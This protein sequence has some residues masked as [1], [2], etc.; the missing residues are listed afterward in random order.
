MLSEISKID[1]TLE[2][3]KDFKLALSEEKDLNHLKA[4][5]QTTAVAV[6]GLVSRGKS[7]LVNK[8]IGLDLLPTG[9]NPV[10][11]G[12][13]FLSSG[14][15]EAF[16]ITKSGKRVALPLEPTEFKSRSRRYDGQDLVDFTYS[17]ALRLPEDVMLIDTKGLDE[18][19]ANFRDDLEEMERSWA[20]QGALGAVMVTSVPP[21]MSAQ[22]A[23]LF[24]ELHRHFDGKVLVVVKQTD[25]S[26]TL[27]EI[28]E[29][30][31]VW[32][33]HG[34]D[35]I[36]ISD[37]KPLPTDIWGNGPLSNLENRLSQMWLVGQ[38]A[39]I[40]ALHSLEQTI[41]TLTESIFTPTSRKNFTDEQLDSLWKATN[42][43]SLLPAAKSISKSRLIEHYARIGKVPVD[44]N[45]LEN[46]LK[47]AKLGSEQAL[48]HIQ[49]ATR[50]N[51]KLKNELSSTAIIE[52]ID[53]Y[54]PRILNKTLE[55]FEIDSP[56]EYLQL[57]FLVEQLKDKGSDWSELFKVCLEYLKKI[58][59]EKQLVDLLGKC[60][61]LLVEPTILHLVSLWSEHLTNPN[62]N[63]AGDQ[64]VLKTIRERLEMLGENHAALSTSSLSLVKKIQNFGRD[65]GQ[66]EFQKY[67]TIAR[68]YSLTFS[69]QHQEN[70]FVSLVGSCNRISAVLQR[71]SVLEPAL[72]EHVVTELSQ[73]EDEWGEKSENQRWAR[74]SY[75]VADHNFSRADDYV[76][77]FRW[78]GL[79]FGVL[80]FF[81]LINQA[82]SW[83]ILFAGIAA[84]SALQSNHYSSNYP[85]TID[86]F[87]SDKRSK[88]VEQRLNGRIKG[89]VFAFLSVLILSLSSNFF[90]PDR[91]ES[92]QSADTIFESNQID[93]YPVN[94][95]PPE[96]TVFTTTSIAQVSISN[97]DLEED[98]IQNGR[99]TELV[100]I[101][102]PSDDASRISYAFRLSDRLSALPDLIDVEYCWINVSSSEEFCDTTQARRFS[103]VS[104]S[105]IYAYTAAVPISLSSGSYSLVT[106][107]SSVDGKISSRSN[108]VVNS[109]LS[110]P[111]TSSTLPYLTERNRYW[112]ANCPKNMT[113]NEF[114]PLRLCHEGRGVQRVQYLLGVDADGYFGNTTHNALLDFQYSIGLTPTGVVDERTWYELDKSQS[115]PGTDLNG[116][117]LVTPDE[118]Q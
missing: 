35:V 96:T 50:R 101:S 17:N 111:S 103:Q 33:G 62:T 118:F 82:F 93:S 69:R 22:D 87:S 5:H 112:N 26:L 59:N 117:G 6:I 67:K 81:T 16:G 1:A 98:L 74:N 19:A 71:L 80:A 25:T 64:H 48:Q 108:L 94:T 100:E 83:T 77:S 78:V 58:S 4:I 8:L 114:L 51:S 88:T 89:N 38:Q 20:T 12:N 14:K 95:D 31:Q 43:R 36:V 52:F 13:G 76:T 85:F 60:G 7:T 44:R 72:A 18:I 45:Q 61:N 113:K 56:T 3:L 104:D 49:Q 10:T 86:S 11:F 2:F 68:Q 40:D 91:A 15:S 53:E 41:T 55:R 102:L 24:K 79:I 46:S 57:S 42:S 116:D 90:I 110:S 65:W 34:A 92:E 105:V 99:G 66:P 29:A 54:A 39:K 70:P 115:G 27:E 63:M 30:A 37:G 109:S 47:F 32:A 97:S 9:P 107:F 23:K 28:N 73:C 106:I 84:I 21:G 75:E